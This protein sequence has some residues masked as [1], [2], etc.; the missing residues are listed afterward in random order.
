MHDA[1]VTSADRDS[2]EISKR[3]FSAYPRQSAFLR[4]HRSPQS[5]HF[6][7]PRR[8]K[9]PASDGL[10]F[11]HI[12]NWNFYE[13]TFHVVLERQGPSDRTRLR[14]PQPD[15]HLPTPPV[16]QPRRSRPAAR[17]SALRQRCVLRS[18][19]A[20]PVGHRPRTPAR[21]PA[22]GGAHRRQ[23]PRAQVRHLTHGQGARREE[24]LPRSRRRSRRDI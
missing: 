17:H 10:Y 21:R 3:G 5:S 19:R 18:V 16:L 2:A 20:G 1:S 22:M 8:P 15:H 4:H 7:P 14:R 11:W 6:P 23:L 13:T 9:L 12:W 24:A